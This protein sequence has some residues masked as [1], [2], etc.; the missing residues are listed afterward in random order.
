MNI[1]MWGYGRGSQRMVSITEA[2]RIRSMNISKRAGLGQQRQVGSDTA[3]LLLLKAEHSEA[4][5]MISYLI[6]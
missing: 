6:S 4:L 5:V 3:K 2:E 1:W